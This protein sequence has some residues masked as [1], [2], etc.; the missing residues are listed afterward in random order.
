M[1]TLRSTTNHAGLQVGK[2]TLGDPAPYTDG[3][4]SGPDSIP[5]QFLWD[6]GMLPNGTINTDGLVVQS[7]EVV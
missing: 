7:E 5:D 4:P 6:D 1:G 2:I 3:Q